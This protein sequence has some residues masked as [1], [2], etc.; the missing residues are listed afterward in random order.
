MFGAALAADL[1]IGAPGEDNGAGK[2]HVTYLNSDGTVNSPVSIANPNTAADAFGTSLAAGDF[3][4][5]GALDLAIGAPGENNGAGKV[6][7][8]YLNSDGTVKSLINITNSNTAAD[9]FGTSLAAGDFD[10]DGALDLAIG[11]PGE[12]NGAGKVYVAYLNS[13]GTVKN[14]NKISDP[15]YAGFGHA[16]SVMDDLDGDGR[17]EFAATSLEQNHGA[18]HILHPKENDITFSLTSDYGY[19]FGASL[20]YVGVLS[21]GQNVLATGIPFS[22]HTEGSTVS[23]MNGGIDQGTVLLLNFGDKIRITTSEIQNLSHT[24]LVT[25]NEQCMSK[26]S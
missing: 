5:D 16:L 26:T 2:V 23:S 9:A 4:G 24:P 8:A 11:A 22:S 17:S 7:V 14:T 21:D 18:I 13:N 19:G 20:T 6:Y 25:Y 15:K 12:D 3:D 1:A 10:G